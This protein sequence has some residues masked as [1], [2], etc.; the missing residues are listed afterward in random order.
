M[1]YVER[2]EVNRFSGHETA[3]LGCR[4]EL[5]NLWRLQ[6]SVLGRPK[7]LCGLIPVGGVFLVPR[8]LEY[9]VWF[10]YEG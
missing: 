6:M 4:L 1:Q 8:S 5:P 9:E 2:C 3:I 10:S 7:M